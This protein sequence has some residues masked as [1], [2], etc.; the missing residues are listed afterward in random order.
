MS[1]STAPVGFAEA[2]AGFQA[3]QETYARYGAGDTEPRW[4]FESLI[5]DTYSGAEVTVPTTVRGWQLYSGMRG[6]GLA[7]AALARAARRAIEAARHDTIAVARF[8]RRY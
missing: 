6:N 1:K 8:A 3:V 5:D 7:A 2:L 4:V